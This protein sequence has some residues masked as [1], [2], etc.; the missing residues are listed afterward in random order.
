MRLRPCRARHVYPNHRKSTNCYRQFTQWTAA[1]HFSNSIAKH[2][3]WRSTKF[4]VSFCRFTLWS[5]LYWPVWNLASTMWHQIE[6]AI[7]IVE[8]GYNKR[9]ASL[10]SLKRTEVHGSFDGFAR[11]F[12][13]C[14]NCYPVVDRE[15]ESN[16]CAASCL[17]WSGDLED[18]VSYFGLG[19]ERLLARTGCRDRKKGEYLSF[20]SPTSIA[21]WHFFQQI[22]RLDKCSICVDL[23]SSLSLPNSFFACSFDVSILI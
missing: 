23:F 10:F 21:T 16:E 19:I 22:T 2:I 7:H 9:L 11:A 13:F 18:T 15:R 14:F 17:H 8:Y 1:N 6:R 4:P 20:Q 3:T 12:D 5:R